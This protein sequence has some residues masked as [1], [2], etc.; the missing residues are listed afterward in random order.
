VKTENINNENASKGGQ[1]HENQQKSKML[2]FG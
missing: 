1:M 2:F